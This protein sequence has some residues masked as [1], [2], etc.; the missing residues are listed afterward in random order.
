[1]TMTK[2]TVLPIQLTDPSTF[3]NFLP[4][5]NHQTLSTLKDF[6]ES[7][8]EVRICYLWGSMGTGKTHL[9]MASCKLIPDSVYLPLMDL[10]LEPANLDEVANIELIC[11]DD[12]HSVAAQPSW[13]SALFALFE[14]IQTNKNFLVVS[15]RFPASEMRFGLKDLVNRFQGRQI[16]KLNPLSN[17]ALSLL[18]NFRAAKRG[19][20]LDESVIQFILRRYSRDVHSLM[21]L[22]VRLDDLTMQT[23]RRVTIPLLKRLDEFKS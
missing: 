12:I 2:Q 9:L 20:T 1:M 21:R 11:I 23:H 18:L 3:D 14:K 19:L 8:S 15:S 7:Q 16:L 17:Q 6:V 4:D 10:Q 5:R 22:L 13:E